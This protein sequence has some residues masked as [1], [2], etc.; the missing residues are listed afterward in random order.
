MQANAPEPGGPHGSSWEA[1]YGEKP[2][3]HSD[4]LGKAATLG[5]HP[6][7]NEPAPDDPGLKAKRTIGVL[8][9]VFLGLFGLA[10][11]AIII[12]AVISVMG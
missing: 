5:N 8:E 4:A 2:G 6:R 11:L 9:T 10:L 12:L 1:C 7:G 3:K